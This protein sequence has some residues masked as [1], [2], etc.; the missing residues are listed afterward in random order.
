MPKTLFPI[1]FRS[2]RPFRIL[3]LILLVGSLA[4][5][6][7]QGTSK[8]LAPGPD[9]SN[10]LPGIIVSGHSHAFHPTEVTARPLRIY[11]T[12]TP[13]STPK[14]PVPTPLPQVDRKPASP[15]PAPLPLQK[16]IF[17]A[18]NSSAISYANKS[19]LIAYAKLL[20]NNPRFSIILT[21][22]TDPSG[23]IRYNRTLG[24]KR[25][26]A[27]KRV[28]LAHGIKSQRIR[29]YSDG[30]KPVRFLSRCRKGPCYARDRA[31]RIMVLKKG[32][33]SGISKTHTLKKK[34]G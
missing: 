13:V 23:T 5:C 22:H 15:P 32:F 11:S 3:S 27:A 6:A 20:H 10:Q 8:S 26:I 16:D 1:L 19:V 4:A 33:S 30:K 25:A 21:G 17:F 7:H 29:V 18:F 2:T 24:F 14:P 34:K 9:S 12:P 31:V 28:F